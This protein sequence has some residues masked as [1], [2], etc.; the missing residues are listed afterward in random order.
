MALHPRAAGALVCKQDSAAV[1]DLE[2][3]LTSE[4][5]GQAERLRSEIVENKYTHDHPLG[6]NPPFAM[7]LKRLAERRTYS[8]SARQSDEGGLRLR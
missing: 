2:P 7:A 6:R 8:Q 5:L 4:M 3:K 1:S